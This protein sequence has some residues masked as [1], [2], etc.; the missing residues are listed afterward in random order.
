MPRRTKK[1]EVRLSVG[2]Y[3]RL[4]EK[5]NKSGLSASAFIRMAVVGVEIREA[6]S[7]DVPQLIR[8]VRRVGNNINQILVLARTRGLLNVSELEKA[9]E[10]N[11][12]VE[13]IIASAYERP[14]L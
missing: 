3:N 1:V 10:D 11:R 2:E 9:L 14:W 12:A 5:V 7:A 8:E 6:P 13:K 4:M